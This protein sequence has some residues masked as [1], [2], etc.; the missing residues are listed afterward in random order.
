VFFGG[1]IFSV[2]LR[3]HGGPSKAMSFNLLGAMTGGMLE[4]HAMVFGFQSLYWFAI[5]L[6]GLAVIAA[7]RSA[8][9]FS[10]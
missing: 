9:S 3:K 2:L 6:Y 1:I 10:E 4:Y 5:G 8:Y 7:W